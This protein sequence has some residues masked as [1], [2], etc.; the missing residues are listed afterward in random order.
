[1]FLQFP[2]IVVETHSSFFA[3]D[4]NT[5]EWFNTSCKLYK[6]NALLSRKNGIIK[7]RSPIFYSSPT[8]LTFFNHTTTL[9]DPSNFP[10]IFAIGVIMAK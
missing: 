1:M 10:I 8:S 5:L 6:A 3:S 9:P 2:E 4:K 7:D